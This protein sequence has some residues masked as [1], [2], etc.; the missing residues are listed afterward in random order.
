MTYGNRPPRRGYIMGTQ[1]KKTYTALTRAQEKKS[2]KRW[3]MLPLFLLLL[4]FFVTAVL[5]VSYMC[6]RGEYDT[7]NINGDAMISPG[8]GI[9]ADR[10][11]KN[12]PGDNPVFGTDA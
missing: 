6:F 9:G 7:S 1:D 2:K 4:L 11:A 10:L 3:L 12:C 5:S 8:I